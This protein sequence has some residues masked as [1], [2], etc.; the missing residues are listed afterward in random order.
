[1]QPFISSISCSTVT[2]IICSALINLLLLVRRS[3]VENALHK[4]NYEE[5]QISAILKSFKLQ[6]FFFLGTLIFI[7]TSA[8]LY[9][10]NNIWELMNPN[11]LQFF[12]F[13]T[14]CVMSFLK[15]LISGSVLAMLLI[16]FLN[17]NNN[18][19]TK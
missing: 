8:V 7:C 12:I 9:C 19:E 5:Y 6:G 15:G 18:K 14:L 16:F 3:T 2:L 13:S 11:T 4:M 1:M 17:R 10:T